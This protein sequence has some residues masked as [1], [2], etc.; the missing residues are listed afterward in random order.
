ME[1]GSCLIPSTISPALY[2]H[3]VF[4]NWMVLRVESLAV[5][6]D[7]HHVLVKLAERGIGTAF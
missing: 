5:C 7:E 2:L 3:A 4:V 1:E 6:L